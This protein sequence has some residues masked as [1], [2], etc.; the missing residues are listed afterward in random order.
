MKRRR[1]PDTWNEPVTVRPAYAEDG[2]TLARLAALDSAPVPG[3]SVLV[4]EVDGELRAALSLLDGSAIADP[5]CR[6]AHLIVLLRAHAA[7]AGAASSQRRR[8]RL[9]YA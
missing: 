5:F 7:G 3:G 1:R 4:A 8:L 9:G 2:H 6:T